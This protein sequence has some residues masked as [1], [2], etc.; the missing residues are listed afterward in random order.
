VNHT[1]FIDACAAGTAAP[2]E[3]DDYVEFWHTHDTGNSL[4]EFLG[5]TTEEFDQLLRADAS[6]VLEKAIEARVQH[7]QTGDASPCRPDEAHEI[8]I[9]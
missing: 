5:L 8:T 4:E 6:E 2:S 1:T 3:L 7:M 9:T